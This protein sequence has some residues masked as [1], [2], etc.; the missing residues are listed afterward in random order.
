MQI[1]FLTEFDL[2]TSD[3]QNGKLAE[4]ELK[5]LRQKVVCFQYRTGVFSRFK[6]SFSN[7][8]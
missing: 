5:F 6:K 7:L 2:E 1:Q 3:F 8:S 4:F